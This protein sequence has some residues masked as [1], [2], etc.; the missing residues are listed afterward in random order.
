[1]QLN[2]TELVFQFSSV[3]SLSTRRNSKVKSCWPQWRHWRTLCRRTR[4]QHI[5]VDRD[6]VRAT[7]S[8]AWTG[9]DRSPTDTPCSCL[10]TY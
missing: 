6:S 9:V 8:R 10:R 4:K 1:M 5:D 7:R 3:L 2:A